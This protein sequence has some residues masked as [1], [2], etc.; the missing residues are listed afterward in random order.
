MRS[1]RAA[2]GLKPAMPQ[3]AAGT[4]IEP[5]VSVPIAPGTTPAATATAEP[6][7]EPPGHP[8]RARAG[9]TGVPKCGFRPSPENASSLR[10]VLPTQ[11]IPAAASRA[12]TG[13]SAAAGA[14]SRRSA[15]AAVVGVPAT[16]IRSFHA[17]GTPSSGPRGAP[18]RSRSAL[19]APRAA[20]APPSAS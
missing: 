20:P 10:F 4:R 8:A 19:A 14:A 11:T 3:N 9:S 17:T 5:D 1:T 6:D 15:D 7:D 2:V 16:S 18:A 12:T 13:A